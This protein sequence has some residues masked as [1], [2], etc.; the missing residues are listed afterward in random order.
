M[1][2]VEL[3]VQDRIPA[4]GP[5]AHKDMALDRPADILYLGDPFLR[6]PR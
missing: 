3:P 6:T 4:R 2:R 5:Q 1:D